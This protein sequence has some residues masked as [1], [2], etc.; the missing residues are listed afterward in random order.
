MRSAA[1]GAQLP[2]LV[3]TLVEI[4]HRL[5]SRTP[6]A[7]M[8]V[9]RWRNGTAAPGRLADTLPP[10]SLAEPVVSLPASVSS[11]WR[12]LQ[13]RLLAAAGL[14]V[15]V[16]LVAYFGRAGYRDL[17]NTPVGFLDALYY[18]HRQHHHRPATATSR[19]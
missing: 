16:T 7:R 17:N 12:R 9:E 18:S 19:R 11:P 13:A 4:Q 2:Q 5:S 3:E 10:V 1:I 6:R 8:F 14:L 15:F